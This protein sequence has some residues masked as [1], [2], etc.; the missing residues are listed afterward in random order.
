MINLS[1]FLKDFAIASICCSRPNS[2]A[3][4]WLRPCAPQKHRVAAELGRIA[5]HDPAAIGGARGRV[6]AKPIPPRTNRLPLRS[7]AIASC[8]NAQGLI[9]IANLIW[10]LY[11]IQNIQTETGV[12]GA[13]RFRKDGAFPAGDAAAVGRLSAVNI[14]TYTRAAS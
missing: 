2:I 11:P 13:T 3:A 8:C 5:Y 6:A 14:T 4:F 12:N 1:P 7:G 9:G 10:I